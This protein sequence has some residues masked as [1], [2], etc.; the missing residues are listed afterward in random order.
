MLSHDPT[1]S[2]DIW[3]DGGGGGGGSLAIWWH[4]P[5]ESSVQKAVVPIPKRERVSG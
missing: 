2:N 3:V 5:V 1:L 4:N